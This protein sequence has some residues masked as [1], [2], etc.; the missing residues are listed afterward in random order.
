ML[1][2]VLSSDFHVSEPRS[3]EEAHR[4]GIPGL[5]AG[6][7]SSK[8]PVPTGDC[9]SLRLKCHDCGERGNLP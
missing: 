1:P 3:V 8:R 9:D 7:R 2:L 6:N 5:S 4:S